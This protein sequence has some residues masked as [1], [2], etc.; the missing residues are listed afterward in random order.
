MS[1]EKKG[2]GRIFFAGRAPKYVRRRQA[3]LGATV[4]ELQKLRCNLCG[5]IFT[6]RAPPGVGSQKYDAESAS[7]IALLDGTARTVA[8]TAISTLDYSAFTE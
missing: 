2:V 3:P 6:A 4:Y 1:T 5:T 8:S 7:M